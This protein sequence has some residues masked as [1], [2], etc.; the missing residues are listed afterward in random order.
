MIFLGICVI[1]GIFL[2]TLS[3]SRTN[4]SSPQAVVNTQILGAL[5]DP[6]RLGGYDSGHG[7]VLPSRMASPTMHRLF[8][9]NDDPDTGGG[10]RTEQGMTLLRHFGGAGLHV[11]DRTRED[12]V[13]SHLQTLSR[14]EADTPDAV[15]A[16]NE[17]LGHYGCDAVVWFPAKDH[18]LAGTPVSFVRLDADQHITGEHEGRLALINDHPRAINREIANRIEDIVR[19]HRMMGYTVVELDD[20]ELEAR[21]RLALEALATRLTD[22]VT[23]SFQLLLQESELHGVLYIPFDSQ[24]TT[25]DNVTSRLYTA[26]LIEGAHVR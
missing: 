26:D 19:Q 9:V 2:I 10:L 12:E 23:D 16:L 7:I 20:Y 6:I 22:D 5:N 1:G 8:I 14:A 15:L 25:A 4:T 21:L 11:T 18:E 24:R 3:M 13:R 17:I